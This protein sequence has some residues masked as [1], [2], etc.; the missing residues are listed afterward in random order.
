MNNQEAKFILQSCRHNGADAS[1]PDLQEALE[2]ARRDPEVG[3][4]HAEE[5]AIDASVSRKLKAIPIPPHLKTNILAARKVAPAVAWWQQGTW[6]AAAACFVALA[7]FSAFLF[8][9]TSGNSFTAF[10]ADMTAF[11]TT[12]LDRLD[13]DT[14]EE[15]TIRTWLASHRGHGDFVLPE[16]VEELHKLGCR[17]L[18]W[19]GQKVTLLC[20]KLGGPQEVHLLV[21][22]RATFRQAPPEGSPQFE[23]S[24]AWMTA[25]WSHRDKVYLL[26]GVGDRGTLQKYF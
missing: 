16:R 14:S 19:K 4:W 21:A 10:R 1:D 2:H 9:Q 7:A 12:R 20:F 8:Y 13:V 23:K 11:L 17:V 15:K 5:Q 18:D 22:D 25:S 6:I 3:K 24:G 26:A